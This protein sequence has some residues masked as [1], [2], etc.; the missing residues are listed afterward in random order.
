[1][2]RPHESEALADLFQNAALPPRP[3]RHAGVGRH[4]SVAAA[5]SFAISTGTTK[6]EK[7]NQTRV[8]Q[9]DSKM[10]TAFG[11]E[12]HGRTP[13]HEVCRCLP[14]QVEPPSTATLMRRA[15]DSM[16]VSEETHRDLYRERI[17]QVN[18]GTEEEIKLARQH[19]KKR[20]WAF[21]DLKTSCDEVERLAKEMADAF[22]QAKA[23]YE[24]TDCQRIMEDA[25]DHGEPIP[26]CHK[27]FM[28]VAKEMKEIS[29]LIAPHCKIG[30]VRMLPL[31]SIA[32]EN[33]P[34]EMSSL[35]LVAFTAAELLLRNLSMSP[36]RPG[37]WPRSLRYAPGKRVAASRAFL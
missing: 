5:V 8:E 35:P 7:A 37:A 2:W 16:E 32:G 22:D 29:V 11:P 19:M 30:A 23:T 6:N 36:S 26:D 34:K 21:K 9:S 14:G 18:I 12:L 20:D 10:D 1:M 25:E 27:E 24:E 17:D 28:K 13:N 33:R 31:Q 4:S 15:I 3:A